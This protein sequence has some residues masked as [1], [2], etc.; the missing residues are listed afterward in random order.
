MSASSTPTPS[1]PPNL[2]TE[3]QQVRQEIAAL[4]TTGSSEVEVARINARSALRVSIAGAAAT[5]IFALSG[6]FIMQSGA[7]PTPPP[8]ETPILN[9]IDQRE[10]AGI[11]AEADGSWAPL[12]EDSP[13]EEQCGINDYVV[14]QLD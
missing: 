2:L 4:Q 12:P 7:E 14:D 5:G 3:L 1:P 9:C 6:I 13:V 10:A 11:L 8:A